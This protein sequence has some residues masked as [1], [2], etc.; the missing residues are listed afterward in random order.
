MKRRF[1]IRLLS[2]LLIIFAGVYGAFWVERYRQDLE[3]RERAATI[4]QALEEELRE[5]SEYGPLVE[6]AMESALEEFDTARGQG[7]MVPPAYYREPGA[8][9]ASTSVWEAT[10]ASGGVNLLDPKLFY[11]LAAFY[12]RVESFSQRY[13]RYNAFTEAELLPLLS[14]GA[15]AFYDPSS[16]EL[17]PA[18]RVHLDQLR[19]LQ[20]E[21]SAIIARADSL[22]DVVRREGKRLR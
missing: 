14:L 15:E 3:D 10:V 5:F 1:P 22:M 2:E 13:V 19:T 11:A 4:L 12:N 7:V 16:G 18:F 21:A 6:A 8:E 9:T 17:S 20:G